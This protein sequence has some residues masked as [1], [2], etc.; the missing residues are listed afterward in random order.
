M[1]SRFRGNDRDSQRACL[2]KNTSSVIPQSRARGT[3]ILAVRMG[4][5]PMPRWLARPRLRDYLVP[6]S[7]AH[8]ADGVML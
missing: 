1:D 7:A 4:K 5:M 8:F 3:A 2:T 6:D